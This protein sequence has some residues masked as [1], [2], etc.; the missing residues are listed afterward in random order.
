MRH[1][2]LVFKT[3]L[4]LALVLGLSFAVQY[5]LARQHVSAAFSEE[6]RRGL[7]AAADLFDM[8][9]KA[10]SQ[11][12][13]ADARLFCRD[14][15]VVSAYRIAHSGEMDVDQAPHLQAAQQML[16]DYFA[17]KVEGL[18]ADGGGAR[19]GLHF[20]LPTTRSL[21]RVWRPNQDKCDDISTFRETVIAV[22]TAPHSP[23]KGIEVGRGGFAVRGIA[24]VTAPDGSHMGTVE[25]LGNFDGALSSLTAADSSR[26][27][28]VLMDARLLPIATELK[29]AE[30]H[31]VVDG[32]F[33]LVSA[34]SPEFFT[35]RLHAASLARGM[36]QFTTEEAG[37]VL[38]GMAPIS[39]YSGKHVGVLVI[40]VSTDRLAALNAGIMGVFSIVGLVTLIA[41]IITIWV[42]HRALA[43]I[44]TTAHRLDHLAQEAVEA[45]HQIS[46]ASKVQA[47]D[48]SKQAA[49]LQETSASSEQ[50]AA[51]VKSCHSSA[52][53]SSS[54]ADEA[55]AAAKTGEAQ[56][57]E[58]SSAM[59]RLQDSSR[60]ASKIISTINEIA[61]QTNILA[62]NAAV[63]AA[64]A[65][66]A[67]AGFAVVAEEVRR[68]ATRCATA[69]N[70]TGDII[71][72]TI[73]S[74]EDGARITGNVRSCFTQIAEKTT[75]LDSRIRDI[76]QSMDEQALGIEQINGA[77]VEIDTLTQQH[78]SSAEEVAASSEE[79][80]NHANSL[81]HV[82]DTLFIVIDGT[83]YRADTQCKQPDPG[84]RPPANKP[85][86]PIHGFLP[87]KAG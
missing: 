3:S 87:A 79:I 78:A 73:E 69:A 21:L 36:E 19:Y 18:S 4:L 54:V 11:R 41:V 10:E 60:S 62:L 58:L 47:E 86:A 66:E 76:V 65:G 6:G 56:I 75:T 1:K 33:V 8:Q 38:V 12:A 34:S 31:P 70:E 44:R 55:V 83:A 82:A 26:E 46:N 71:S 30:K 63:E 14:E 29:D 2:S 52:Q 85:K 25:M 64:R 57:G 53:Q 42:I 50:I 20:H 23:V 27:V 16:K 37:G 72:Q 68:L 35:G 24:P 32:A 49:A 22:N 5:L 9:L 43:R 77:L 17:L 59:T 61:F 39:D 40:A 13:L 74:S 7:R 67:G 84:P 51:M 28:A 45:T 80:A 15:S 81:R 48:A